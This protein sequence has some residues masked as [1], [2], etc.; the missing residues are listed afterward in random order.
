MFNSQTPKIS[1]FF[2]I[3]SDTQLELLDL[4]L[5]SLSGQSFDSFELIFISQQNQNL[6][7]EPLNLLSHYPFSDLTLSKSKHFKTPLIDSIS[8]SDVFNRAEGTHCLWLAENSL[9]YMHALEALHSSWVSHKKA[10]TLCGLKKTLLSKDSNNRT[11]HSISKRIY[12]QK[13]QSLLR[14]LTTE[15][16]SS[17]CIPD[18]S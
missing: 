17:S 14:R 3:S 8:F 4:S 7:E 12:F 5:F 16:V 11:L 13:D 18:L 6:P 1:V 10:L 15:L 2:P 9:M